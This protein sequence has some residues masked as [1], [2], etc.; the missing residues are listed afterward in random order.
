MSKVNSFSSHKNT[1]YKRK[2]KE[3]IQDLNHAI[4]TMVGSN[5]I[6]AYALVCFDSDGGARIVWDTGS[7]MPMWAFPSAVKEALSRDVE[8][9]GVDET[10]KPKA[11]QF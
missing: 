8:Q 4:K 7:V 11:D 10:W 6:R 1:L 3:K 2:R 5:D 9:S